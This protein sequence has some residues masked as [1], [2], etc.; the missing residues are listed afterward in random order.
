MQ[1]SAPRRLRRRS[2]RGLE[3]DAG[4][5]IRD[6]LFSVERLAAHAATLA[7]RHRVQP[8]GLLTASVAAR[9]QDNGAV[10]RECF[11]AIA[12]AAH[13]RSVVTPAAEWILDNFHVVD[14][15]L[16]SI[17]HDCTPAFLRSLPVLQEGPLRNWPRVYALLWDFVA[18]T[19][20]RFDPDALN[21]YLQGYQSVQP[22]LVRELWAVP[23]MLRCLFVENLRRCAAQVVDAQGGRREADAFADEVLGTGRRTHGRAGGFVRA[24]CRRCPLACIP[25]AAAASAA[26]P[27]CRTATAARAAQCQAGGFAASTSRSGCGRS[28][29][30]RPPPT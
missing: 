11:D 5:P 22:L 8:S 4:A 7:R 28:I 9:A 18:H 12:E 20:S 6:E 30:A 23:V 17:A 2:W 26:R 10:L 25:R 24:R 13:Q 27:G 21:T 14:E 15:Q 19:D 16:K 1:Q 3:D 29:P